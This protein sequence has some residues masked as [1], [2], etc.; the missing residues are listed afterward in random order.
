MTDR[1]N[2][3]AVQMTGLTL[4]VAASALGYAGHYVLALVPLALLTA[5]A[6]AWEYLY[7]ADEVLLP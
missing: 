4:V 7:R 2:P 1:D 6:I 5:L 3:L